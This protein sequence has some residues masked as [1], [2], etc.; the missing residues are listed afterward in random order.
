[1]IC[2]AF[3][4]PVNQVLK[5][6]SEVETHDGIIV[7]SSFDTF[8]F[9][10]KS[11]QEYLTALYLVRMPRI[12]NKIFMDYNLANESA[13]ATCLAID[14]TMF[15]SSLIFDTVICEDNEH[16]NSQDIEEYYKNKGNNEKNNMLRLNIFLIDYLL[17]NQTFMFIQFLG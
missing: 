11:I 13:I 6:I 14:S 1:M 17:K 5:V 9:S 16:R 7:Q 8:S 3:N 10:H 4:L 15:F 12:P 2:N